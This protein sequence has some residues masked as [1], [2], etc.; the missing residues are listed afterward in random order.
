MAAYPSQPGGSGGYGYVVGAPVTV[1]YFDGRLE[2]VLTVDTA[3]MKSAPSSP[4]KERLQ[5]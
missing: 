3:D 5:V 2:P 4:A 1:Q